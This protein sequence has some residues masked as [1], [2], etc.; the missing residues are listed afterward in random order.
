MGSRGNLRYE[1]I[2]EFT[3][4]K[5]VSDTSPVASF[6]LVRGRGI[7]FELFDGTWNTVGRMFRDKEDASGKT[8]NAGVFTGY[9]RIG[10]EPRIKFKVTGPKL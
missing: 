1:G 8:W 4:E 3:V 10:K 5:L 7:N 6:G 2:V 9:Y